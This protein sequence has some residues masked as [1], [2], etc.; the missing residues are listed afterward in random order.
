MRRAG[1]P[2][3]GLS[4]G[5]CVV[6]HEVHR[7]TLVIRCAREPSGPATIPATTGPSS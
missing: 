5:S 7:R 6:R 1:P 4:A 2:W 3:Q